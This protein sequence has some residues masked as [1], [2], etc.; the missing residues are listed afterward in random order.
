MAIAS[1]PTPHSRNSRDGFW[2]IGQSG[3]PAAC[4]AAG[5][6]ASERKDR[7]KLRVDLVG[8]GRI[9]RTF[10]SLR[11]AEDNGRWEI[12][13]ALKR[14]AA[15]SDER[16]FPVVETL[17]CLGALG[18]GLL[19]D[20]TGPSAIKDYGADLLWLADV[21]TVGAA[22]L[23][24]AELER[25]LREVSRQTHRPR[26]L[27]GAIGGVDA[28]SAIAIDPGAVV[29]ILAC[30]TS[31]PVASGKV[32]DARSVVSRA[33][34]VNVIAT[35]AFASR[36]LNHTPVDHVAAGEGN[37]ADLALRALAPMERCVSVSIRSSMRNM[38]PRSLRPA[39][40]RGCAIAI[41]LVG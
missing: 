8:L 14:N 34:G 1:R 22:A 33:E 13:G 17:A 15:T 35:A 2:A 36:A 25:D 12:V 40:C 39:P 3:Y 6:H 29:S 30:T 31:N 7:T 27:P 24:S 4:R 20:F 10:L 41:D 38:G 23:V 18:P 37:N 19:I 16:R 21:W 11:T 28:L 5:E 26:L 9:T 32:D